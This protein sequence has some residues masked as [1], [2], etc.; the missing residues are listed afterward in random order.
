MG[1]I[2]NMLDF[3][4]NQVTL[5]CMISSFL[6]VF[7]SKKTLTFKEPTNRSHPISKIK[8]LWHACYL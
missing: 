5:A 8:S 7:F 1:S 3:L 6:Q 2:N 4:E